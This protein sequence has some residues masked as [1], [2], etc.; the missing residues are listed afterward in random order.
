ME[1]DGDLIPTPT[2]IREV[3]QQINISAGEAVSLIEVFMPASRFRHRLLDS[4]YI[5][6]RK[7]RVGLQLKRNRTLACHRLSKH[8]EG[9][10]KG[11]LSA[12]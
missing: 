10:I 12:V 3:M 2:S 8:Q 1:R 9:S 11:L 5:T 4:L 6:W 7:R